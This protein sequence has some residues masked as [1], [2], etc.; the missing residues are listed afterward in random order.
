M[1]L[2]L[3]SVLAI[4]GLMILPAAQEAAAAPVAT[5]APQISAALAGGSIEYIYYYHGRY[6][7]YHWRGRYYAHRY[8][9]Y[10]GWHYY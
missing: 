7:P 5:A 1:R 4:A 10:G 3:R 2:N 8:Y 9:R 6:Y